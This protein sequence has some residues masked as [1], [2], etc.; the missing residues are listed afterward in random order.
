M[1]SEWEGRTEDSSRHERQG[2]GSPETPERAVNRPSF[3]PRFRGSSRVLPYLPLLFL[4]GCGL[5]QWPAEGPLVSPFG[6][7]FLGLVPSLHR[8]VDIQL[9]QGTP[10][11]A[12]AKGRVRFA[13]TQRGYGTVVWL[14]HSGHVLTVYAHL[15]ELKVNPGEEVGGGQI[16]GLSGQ[17]GNARGPH[18]H[19]EIWRW[20]REVDPVPL[21]GGFPSSG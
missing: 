11:R 5:P 19:F 16:I 17:S 15:S 20:G 8:G 14:E 1:T 21:L 3:L 7:R 10:V 9:P 4:L 18:L 13:G 2:P 6:I 12:M